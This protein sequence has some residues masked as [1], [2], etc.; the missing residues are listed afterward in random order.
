MNL[1]LGLKNTIHWQILKKPKLILN[2]EARHHR[3]SSDSH[4]RGSAGGG[5]ISF[6]SAGGY[7][8]KEMKTNIEYQ[9]TIERTPTQATKIHIPAPLRICGSF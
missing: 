7:I 3:S 4:E 8:E 6:G 5:I 9:N 1:Q 2:Q